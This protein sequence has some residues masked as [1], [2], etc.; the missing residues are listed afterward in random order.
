[1]TVSGRLQHVIKRS[2]DKSR[3]LTVNEQ[4]IE[5][6]CLIVC[7][8]GRCMPHNAFHHP[9]NLLLNHVTTLLQLQLDDRLANTCP[10]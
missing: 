7:D 2:W 8:Y 3:T 5:H 9:S 10:E 6:S 1:M 4:I